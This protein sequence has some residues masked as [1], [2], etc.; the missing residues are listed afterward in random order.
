MYPNPVK[1][2][3]LY[4]T[5]NSSNAKTVAVYDILGKQ[6]INSKTSNNT[7]NVA[8]LKSGAYIVRITEEGKTDTRK[9]IIE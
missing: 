7:V 4:I 1:N 9:L 5:S 6:V 8:N 3:N 2:G